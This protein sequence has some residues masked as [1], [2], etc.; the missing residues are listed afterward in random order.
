MA[1]SYRKIINYDSTAFFYLKVK[2][3]IWNLN[4]CIWTYTDKYIYIGSYNKVFQGFFTLYSKMNKRALTAQKIIDDMFLKGNVITVS[5]ENLP[6][7]MNG[8][9]VLWPLG[10]KYLINGYKHYM[11]YLSETGRKESRKKYPELVKICTTLK[12]N[13]NAVILR[14]KVKNF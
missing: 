11:S 7:N 10:R 8:N 3:T 9:D 2:K 14:I 12:E 1:S 4:L 5:E 6:H 13:D